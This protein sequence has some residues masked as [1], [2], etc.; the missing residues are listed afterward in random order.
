MT[1]K[2][3]KKSNTRLAHT[4][5]SKDYTH[6]VVNPPVY[7]ASTCVFETYEDL[8]AGVA[9]PWGRK[10]FYGRKGT[11]THW[12]LED[13]ISE[14]HGAELTHLYP[15]GVAAISGA[16]LSVISAGDHI[17]ITDSAYEPTRGLANGLLKRLGVEITY[18]DPT[19]GESIKD[20]LRD[21]T[22]AIWL[23]SPGSLTFEMQD[24]PAISSVA[25]DHPKKPYVMVDNTWSSPLL[26]QPL[27]LG[28]DMVM[29]AVTKYIG[30]HSDVMMGS[31]S[32]N[33]RASNA[34]RRT[35]SQLGQSV[36][37]DDAA[38]ALRGLRTLG[39]RLERQ[40]ATAMTVAKW[41]DAH[42]AVDTVLFPALESD[43]GH[44]IWQRDI[45]GAAGLFSFVLKEGNYEDTAAMVD[46]MRFFSMGFSWGGFES[47]ILPSDPGGCRSATE[48]RAN[49]PLIRLS[50]GL[51]EADDLIK[52]LDEGLTR[53]QAALQ[54]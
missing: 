53:F 33:K 12:S 41:L 36:S 30:G 27:A 9:D 13:A 7:R 52:D 4:G 23:E 29:E 48:W 10:L 21:N 50:I 15:S 2:V 47:L 46:H 43:P 14:L 24:I 5:R 8:R 26:C 3:D 39:V 51:E 19:L 16:I 18:F 17:L 49:G 31:V 38:L 25:A 54:T 32:A 20:L 34:L 37:A 40:G 28:A 1:R 6:G 44:A 22:S 42:P 35:T 11:P 45:A